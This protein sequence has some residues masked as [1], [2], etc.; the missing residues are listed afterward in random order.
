MSELLPYLSNVPSWDC[1]DTDNGISFW[2]TS[3]GKCAHYWKH[4]LINTCGPKWQFKEMGSECLHAI[5]CVLPS[6]IFG[7][8]NSTRQNIGKQDDMWC[9]QPDFCKWCLCEHF[10]T[11]TFVGTEQYLGLWD[12]SC[13]EELSVAGTFHLGCLPQLTSTALLHTLTVGLS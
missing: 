2:G 7:R 5:L 13:A 10:A 6:E 9:L 11:C 12:R 3:L 4:S 8:P 1:T